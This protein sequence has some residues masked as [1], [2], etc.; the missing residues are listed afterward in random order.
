MGLR[1]WTSLYSYGHNYL[2]GRVYTVMAITTWLDES[3]VYGHKYVVGRVYR[4][5]AI[6][7]WL[8]ESIEL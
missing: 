7:T 1:G 6:T 4:V 3:I 5:M 2:V 8:D